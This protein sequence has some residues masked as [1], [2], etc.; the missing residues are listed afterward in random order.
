MVLRK[1]VTMSVLM[2]NIYAA[3]HR[4]TFCRKENSFQQATTS[5]S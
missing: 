1:R 5:F 3:N 4:V 2:Q